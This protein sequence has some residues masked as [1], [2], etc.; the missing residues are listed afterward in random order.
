M[1]NQEGTIHI[2]GKTNIDSTSKYTVNAIQGAIINLN[3]DANIKSKSK[4]ASVI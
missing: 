3:D 2:T 1:A 4:K